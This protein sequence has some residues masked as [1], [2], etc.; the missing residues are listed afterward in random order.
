MSG[1]KRYFV[2]VETKCTTSIEIV[3]TSDL[4]FRRKLEEGDFDHAETTDSDF[5]GDFD[6]SCEDGRDVSGFA[7]GG[8]APDD[9]P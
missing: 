1:E 3:A 9:P 2:D 6:A 7:N 8:E 4:E 5:V